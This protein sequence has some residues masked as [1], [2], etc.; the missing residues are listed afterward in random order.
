ME[1]LGTPNI[2][3]WDE[4]VHVNVVR[5]LAEHCCLPRLHRSEIGTNYRHWTNNTVWLHKP[6]L[7]FYVTAAVYRLLGGS[8][9]ALRLPGAI[10][11][12]L[13]AV[14]VYVTGRKF[15]NHRIG[16]CGAAI[17]AL[18][19]FTNSLV[20]GRT[21]SGF[22]DL[23]FALLMSMALYLILEWSRSKSTASLRW[24]GLVV[25]LGYLCKGGLALAPFIV[26]GAVAVLAGSARDL[27]P[28]ALQS[29]IVF[30]LVVLPERLYWLT[31][32]PVEFRYE[33]HQQLL[34]LFASI[35]GHGAPWHTYLTYSLPH[36]LVPPMVPFAY[37]SIGWFL[38]SQGHRKEGRVLSV[39]T[40]TYIVPLSLGVSKIDNFV[41]PVLPAIALLVP[42]MV[43]ELKEGDWHRT[44]MGL[45]AASW[46]ALL[47][48]WAIG[49]AQTADGKLIW[50]RLYANPRTLSLLIASTILTLS[51]VIL[52]LTRPGS[53]RLSFSAVML[54]A[55]AL[56]LLYVGKDVYENRTEA[57][58]YDGGLSTPEQS[59]LREAG[60]ELRKLVSSDDL[61]IVS[62]ARG[63]GPKYLY[64]M[65][66]SGA[67]VLDVCKEVPLF[68]RFRERKDIYLISKVPLPATPLE[69]LPLGDLYPVK[70]VDFKAWS[71]AALKACLQALDMSLA[72]TN[73]Q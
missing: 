73:P 4:V 25:G 44:V 52:I 43:E 68:E 5:N 59:R 16:L 26:L 17:F 27:I 21:F 35:E 6:L 12:A 71:S 53:G 30:G 8:L 47:S 18:N 66:W 36:I 23:A 45:C 61:V 7:P 56:F 31:H 51:L 37:F 69:R 3:M 54:A 29:I 63:G 1:G 28:R 15:L 34:H 22:P 9:W 50:S 33:Q 2:T 41:F 39:W 32:Y 49:V 48:W 67:D 10:F 40:L 58:K 60:S 65:Y 46:I 24:F 70:E 55:V 42:A 14:V 19:P 13:T 38:T 64:M 11:A 20:H 62:L 57:T 72:T